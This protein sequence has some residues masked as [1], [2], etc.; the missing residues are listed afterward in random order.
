MSFGLALS[1]R[2]VVLSWF[3]D[4]VL[5]RWLGAKA[6]WVFVLKGVFDACARC[7][8]LAGCA[9]R[10]VSTAAMSRFGRGRMAGFGAGRDGLFRTGMHEAK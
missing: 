1:G 9:R 4:V 5:T 8:G 3:D 6:G 7:S 2:W 10:Q